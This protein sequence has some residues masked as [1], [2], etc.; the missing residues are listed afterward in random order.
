MSLTGDHAEGSIT[1]NPEELAPVP[2]SE[3]AAGAK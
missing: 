1:W 3:C 2:D